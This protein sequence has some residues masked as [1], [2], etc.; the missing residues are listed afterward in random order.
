MPNIL[1]AAHGEENDIVTLFAK[2][3][4]EGRIERKNGNKIVIGNVIKK[5]VFGGKGNLS[6][7]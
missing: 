5:S 7:I 3:K 2:K 4:D 1:N 6:I